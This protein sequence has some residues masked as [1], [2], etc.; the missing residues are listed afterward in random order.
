M[1]TTLWSLAPGMAVVSQ[2]REWHGAASQSACWSLEKNAGVSLFWSEGTMS[3]LTAGEYPTTLKDA[4]PQV[5]MSGHLGNAQAGKWFSEGEPT[6]L[7]HLVVGEGQNAFIANGKK[8]KITRHNVNV[9]RS[10]RH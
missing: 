1:S 7:Y 10:G 8:P 5:H 3:D 9:S 6:G 2:H 4:A